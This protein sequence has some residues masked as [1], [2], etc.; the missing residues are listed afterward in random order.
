MKKQNGQLFTRK[1]ISTIDDLREN[2]ACALDQVARI[3]RI[4][5]RKFRL[6]LARL[7]R[8]LQEHVAGN[9]VGFT[10]ERFVDDDECDPQCVTFEIRLPKKWD[11]LSLEWTV[12]HA[13]LDSIVLEHGWE[14]NGAQTWDTCCLY[15]VH[16]VKGNKLASALIKKHQFGLVKA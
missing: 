2:R 7:V 15:S 14:W 5:D 4:L 10:I 1:D 12:F 8:H 16:P 11:W 6:Y 13:L 9:P 3:E